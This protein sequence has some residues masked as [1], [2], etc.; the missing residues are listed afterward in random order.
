MVR[1]SV[2]RLWFLLF[3]LLSGFPFH[4]TSA[5]EIIPIEYG[6]GVVNTIAAP[7]TSVMYTFNGNIGDLVT[8]RA[9][10]ISPGADPTLS[11]VGPPQQVLVVNDNVLSIPLTTTAQIIFRLQATGP[12]FIVVGAHP[13]ISC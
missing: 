13:A 8:I 6:A 5:Q 10:G 3:L 1:H 4:T 11:L 7:D 9:I 12:H 2:R